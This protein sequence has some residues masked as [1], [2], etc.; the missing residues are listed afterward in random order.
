MVYAELPWSP[1]T[2]QAGFRQ[3]TYANFANAINGVAWWLSEELGSSDD[4]ETL[5]YIG[6]NDLRHNLLLLG[7]VKAGYKMLFTSPFYS[8]PAQVKLINAV[9]CR[10]L[11][12]PEIVPPVSEIISE[13]C[14][15]RIL[16]VPGIEELFGRNHSHYPFEKNFE[17]AKHE[18][19]VVLHTSGSTGFPKP[20]IWTHDWAASFGFERRHPAP[21]GFKSPDSLLYGRTLSL[22]APFHVSEFQVQTRDTLDAMILVPPHIEEIARDPALL[23]CLSEGVQRL[24]WVGG[25]ISAAAGNTVS[26]K[27]R[28][29]TTCGS[30]E[31]GIW[32]TLHPSGLWSS[33]HW[34]YMHV[35][36]S[37]QLDFRCRADHLYE[38]VIKRS[39]VHEEEQPVFKIFPNLQEYSSGDLFTPRP[40]ESHLWR[41][42]G[43]ADDMLVFASG[44]KFH[45]ATVESYIGQ[46]PEVEH[47]LVIGT[48]CQK[49]VLLL[50]MRAD[51]PLK[52]SGERN[53][54]IAR[55]WPTIMKSNETCPVYAQLTK[56]HIIFVHPE[57]LMVKTAKGTIQR[58]ATERL[59]KEELTQLDDSYAT[60][61]H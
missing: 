1:T 19:L 48:Q 22:L 42:Y 23:V 33:V 51:V 27:I 2:F 7:A 52:S 31:M 34:N 21:A 3:V 39:P 35:H 41:H 13:A 57:K 43:R 40:S 9:S 16:Y 10:T 8:T 37:M 24:F 4:F 44:E 45:P 54:A 61:L 49:A 30:T 53:E 11:L 12:V 55:L 20:I 46:H 38:A 32:H 25:G 18:P 5:L 47:V 58:S 59:Y 26:S 60:S 28:L 29:F 36:P 15:M 14:E 6:P 56:D 17:Q 50:A